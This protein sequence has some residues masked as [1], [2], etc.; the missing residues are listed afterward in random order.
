MSVVQIV[1][2]VVLALCS[3][4]LAG[5]VLMLID[6][7]RQPHKRRAAKLKANTGGER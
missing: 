6:A 3:M 2:I 1:G 4:T 7:G 5:I